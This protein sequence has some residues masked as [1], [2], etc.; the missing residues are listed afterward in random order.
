MGLFCCMHIRC[1]VKSLW[2]ISLPIW[3]LPLPLCAHIIYFSVKSCPCTRCPAPSIPSNLRHIYALSMFLFLSRLSIQFLHDDNHKLLWSIQMAPET[4]SSTRWDM[5]PTPGPRPNPICL[6]MGLWRVPPPSTIN[7]TSAVQKFS[8][9][10]GS[11]A[12]S[13]MHNNT[14]L[15]PVHPTTEPRRELKN[16]LLTGLRVLVP[17]PRFRSTPLLLTIY[18]VTVTV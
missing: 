14:S 8:K 10:K 18:V 6:L 13:S 9:N 16:W 17:S 7:C 5:L 12:Q 11:L 2:V 4:V 1:L 3:T 15:E